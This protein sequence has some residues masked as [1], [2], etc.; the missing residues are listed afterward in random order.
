M[1]Q[2]KAE[3]DFYIFSDNFTARNNGKYYEITTKLT[4]YYVDCAREKEE[5]K[6][7][8]DHYEK[9]LAFTSDSGEPES[10]NFY[11]KIDRSGLHHEIYFKKTNKQF[12]FTLDGENVKD[13]LNQCEA[14]LVEEMQTH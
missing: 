7:L 6:Q 14:E 11:T 9:Q 10:E 3:E 5:V 1:T 13:I 2:K 8:L 12:S 4:G